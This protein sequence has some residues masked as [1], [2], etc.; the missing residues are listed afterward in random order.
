MM[1]SEPCALPHNRP[2]APLGALKA[3]GSADTAPNRERHEQRFRKA[4]QD[5]TASTYLQMR[6]YSTAYDMQ[7]YLLKIGGFWL[8]KAFTSLRCSS[9][10]LLVQTGRYHVPELQRKD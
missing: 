1:L 9:H 10:Q 2:G 4:L 6:G 5:A 8:R 7:P 3:H